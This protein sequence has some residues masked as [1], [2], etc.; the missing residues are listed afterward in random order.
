[1]FAKLSVGVLWTLALAIRLVMAVAFA[2]GLFVG[3]RLAQGP[4][5]LGPVLAH[6]PEGIR[7]QLPLSDQAALIWRNPLTDDAVVQVHPA[8]STGVRL[9]RA[10]LWRGQAVPVAVEINAPHARLH[11]DEAG[12]V[13]L[14][15]FLGPQTP[16]LRFVLYDAAAPAD[17][18][19]GAK[20]P[21]DLSAL[22]A[23]LG[24]PSL[25]R[26]QIN[27]AT[28]TVQDAVSGTSLRVEE[29]TLGLRQ[30]GQQVQATGG[31]AVWLGQ[32][33]VRLEAVGRLGPGGAAL[34]LQVPQVRV[35]DLAYLLGPGAMGARGQGS[36]V[37]RAEWGADGRLVEADA[38]VA[39]TEAV[40]RDPASG[41]S[42]ELQRG[43][44]K[45]LRQGD[46]GAAKPV[47]ASVALEGLRVQ[48]PAQRVD[49]TVDRWATTSSYQPDTGALDL[50]G[51]VLAVGDLRLEWSA[52]LGLA[53]PRP[54]VEIRASLPRLTLDQLKQLWPPGVAVKM[55]TW[56]RE[57]VLSG[58]LTSLEV[59]AA[60]HMTADGAIQLDRMQMTGGVEDGTVIFMPPMAPVV[61][62]RGQ[63]TVTPDR[64]DM[65]VSAGREGE[66]TL[67]GG[68]IVITE[69]STPIQQ[70]DIR[71]GIAGPVA[72]LLRALNQEPLTLS[73]SVS[74]DMAGA[75]GQA[76]ATAR[77]AF[78]LKP[79]LA[80]PDVRY[81]A[82]ATLSD[83]TL[84]GLI[85]DHAFTDGA[86][87]I[88]VSPEEAVVAG[89]GKVRDHPLRVRWRRPMVPDA[90][91]ETVLSTYLPV[92]AVQSLGLEPYVRGPVSVALWLTGS[93]LSGGARVEVDATQADIRLTELSA[94]KAPGV[95]FIL[96][97][98]LRQPEAGALDIQGITVD[99]PDIG[100]RGAAALRHLDHAA[101]PTV[102]AQVDRL[103]TGRGD[104]LQARVRFDPADGL[105]AQIS[106]RR[107]NLMPILAGRRARDEDRQ[108]VDLSG[109]D[110]P[111]AASLALAL[112]RVDV[113]PDIRLSDVS[114]RYR[115]SP[116]DALT[117]ATVEALIGG[118]APLRL[119]YD[120][121]G[122]DRRLAGQS[123]DA[124]RFLAALD[125]SEHIRGGT[126]DL[127]AQQVHQPDGE[128]HLAGQL[129]LSDFRVLQAPTLARL[130]SALSLDGLLGIANGNQGL[131][132]SRFAVLFDISPQTV[133]LREGRTAGNALGMTIEGTY[134]RDRDELALRGTAV[135]ASTVN[136]LI[137]EVPLLGAILTGMDGKGLFAGQYRITG[138]LSD[139]QVSLNPLTALAPGIV[140]NIFFVD[141]SPLFNGTAEL[142]PAESYTRNDR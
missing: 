133:V 129:V 14:T 91:A 81:S 136:Q 69:L 137:G 65:A 104:D 45:A 34:R 16:P 73:Q 135:P 122:Q 103:T 35:R 19:A 41:L 59:E 4:I 83:V 128:P 61:Q 88:S 93:D 51:G 8:S 131:G 66:V 30:Q 48:M 15:A 138:P 68:T 113:E 99:G 130:L 141:D 47:Q 74:F 3:L 87:E 42:L 114:L 60:A 127:R 56:T 80:L 98:T 23:D 27:G 44:L 54:R 110:L 32:A 38:D 67:T 120:R 78:P 117:E 37:L 140:R 26:V 57:R 119:T 75:R 70:V 112:E 64:L 125:A 5:P 77:F 111:L 29:M 58:A 139:P 102:A 36:L 100:L 31:L 50:S 40:W 6:L 85:Q 115:S 108:D 126:L 24:L 22:G 1:M 79:G 106:G 95:P 11:R 62:A 63:F 105:S 96:S 25:P 13:T 21:L 121:R 97:A 7:A 17:P 53:G 33:P 39:V 90:Q 124:G 72:D 28:L 20:D 76:S 10:A 46:G 43:R 55:Q 84:P 49:L 9:E 101:G 89:T 71:M 118:D 134:N 12:T 116:R 92:W 132:F 142:D 107:A 82:E 18:N 109:L 123:R 2:G 52:S 86:L 94:A